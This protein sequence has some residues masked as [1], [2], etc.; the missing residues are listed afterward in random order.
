MYFQFG[1]ELLRGNSVALPL[2]L[3]MG[4]QGKLRPG[5]RAIPASIPALGDDVDVIG[6]ALSRRTRGTTPTAQN[7]VAKNPSLLKLYSQ[8]RAMP[9]TAF[10]QGR[11]ASKLEHQLG[12][13]VGGALLVEDDPALTDLI[14]LGQLVTIGQHCWLMDNGNLFNLDSLTTIGDSLEIEFND[15]LTSL[16]GLESLTTL[17]G[18]LEVENN[19]AL[20]TLDGLDGLDGLDN[21]ASVNAISIAQNSNLAQCLVEAAMP[22]LEQNRN[23][24]HPRQR[25]SLALAC[26]PYADDDRTLPGIIPLVEE[27]GAPGRRHSQLRCVGPQ[28]RPPHGKRANLRPA[29]HGRATT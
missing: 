12:C 8:S 5:A 15:H 16:L 9:C 26:L 17:L 25:P 14:G 13:S 18:D 7:W 29:P 23:G 4:I 1:S 6:R 10:L 19:P 21:L 3:L 22:P 11:V 24:E 27:V 20:T 2:R 28:E